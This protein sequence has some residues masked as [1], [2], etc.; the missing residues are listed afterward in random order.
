MPVTPHQ[1]PLFAPEYL[2]HGL[3]TGLAAVLAYAVVHAFSLEYGF[4]G[5]LSAVIVMQIN[6]A[7][8]LRMC[9][10]RLTGTI[11]GAGIGLV[12]LLVVPGPGWPTA[13]ALL[14]SVGFCAYM[15]RHNPRYM[16]A[17]ITVVIIV[18]AGSGE[19]RRILF[20]LHRIL[21]IGIGV[22]SAFLVTI[23]I[24]PHRAG[25]TL[26]MLLRTLFIEAA[27][28][29]ETLVEAFLSRQTTVDQDLL[30][31]IS[32]KTRHAGELLA[33]ALGHERL[34]SSED[35]DTL[36][37]RATALDNCVEQMRAMLHVLNDF[38]ESEGYDIIMATQVRD[39]ALAMRTVMIA[40]GE[41]REIS[42]VDLETAL[43][44]FESRFEELRA[45][46]VTKRF[47]LHKLL[48]VFAFLHAMESMAKGLLR[49]EGNLQ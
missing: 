36:S 43:Q 28:H 20:G 23:F 34:F 44:A 26:R 32:A 39:L 18:V 12:T 8:S 6:V 16:M 30:K 31:D 49:T 14:F 21:E 9:W 1:R 7:D 41:G 45:A 46:G 37:R 29:S 4:W 17:A 19:E 40:I 2:R 22:G 27:H 3:K 42:Q 33:K 38:D 48:Q 15:T 13:L 25:S 5:V 24:W 11:M 47:N 35:L 10:Y